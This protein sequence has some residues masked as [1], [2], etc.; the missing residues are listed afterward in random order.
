[1]IGVTAPFY[2]QSTVAGAA[3]DEIFSSFSFSN[4]DRGVEET[5]TKQEISLE[6]SSVVK[7]A[8]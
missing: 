2:L 6:N 4:N 7:A 8:N 5:P 1:L 3:D